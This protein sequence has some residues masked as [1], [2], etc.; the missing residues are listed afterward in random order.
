MFSIISHPIKFDVISCHAFESYT[1]GSCYYFSIKQRHPLNL[2]SEAI[3]L[4]LFWLKYFIIT[5][6]TPSKHAHISQNLKSE[7]FQIYRNCKFM[8]QIY[9]F[10]KSK[11]LPNDNIS[12]IIQYMYINLYT[13]KHLMIFIIHHIFYCTITHFLYNY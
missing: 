12:I 9:F 6:T 8:Q 13:G 1:N 3:Q 2:V 11:I 10:L 5:I 7:W 4:K